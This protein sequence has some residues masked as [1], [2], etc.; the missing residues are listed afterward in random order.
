MSN[1]ECRREEPLGFIAFGCRLHFR[2]VKG[3]YKM[4]NTEYPISNVEG[5]NRFA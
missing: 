4:S 5:K 3:K 1:F 2:A